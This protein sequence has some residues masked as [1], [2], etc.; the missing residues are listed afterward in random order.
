MQEPIWIDERL[1]LAIHRM[2]IAEHG[3]DDGVRDLSLLA[4]ALARP[5]NVFAYE[6]DATDMARLAAEYLFGICKNHPFVDGNKRTA[7]VV[8][9]TFLNLNSV[10]LEAS[11]EEFYLVT[12]QVAQGELDEPTITEWIRKYVSQP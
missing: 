5:R 11:D 9:E 10:L 3:G 4:S 2:Q 8:C 12:M 6:Q 7:A 1:A